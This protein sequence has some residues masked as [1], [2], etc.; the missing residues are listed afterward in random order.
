MLVHR[1]NSIFNLPSFNF[2]YR[3]SWRCSRI[4]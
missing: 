1:N 3:R 2:Q 4:S